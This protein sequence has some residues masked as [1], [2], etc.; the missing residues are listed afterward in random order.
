MKLLFY[1]RI[2][3]FLYFISL[4]SEKKFLANNNILQLFL[5]LI[6]FNFFEPKYG[7]DLSLK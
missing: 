4:F 2:K 7:S 1:V 5:I 3:S 6:S